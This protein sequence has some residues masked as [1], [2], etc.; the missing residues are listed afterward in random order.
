MS[1]RLWSPHIRELGDRIAALTVA[2]AAELSAY[3]EEIHG[4]G[5]PASAPL[6]DRDPEPV[7]E[8][9]EPAPTAF[10]VLL[11]GFEPLQRIAVIRRVRE[12]TGL[13]MKEAK[14]LVE[15][16]PCVL[17]EALPPAEAES[18]QAQLAAAGAKVSLRPCPA[19]A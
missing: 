2:G 1:N 14:D 10:D 11:N 19:A 5:L 16:G 12:L 3:L 9:E 18:L 17:R 7:P 13:G 6:L 8:E 4:L 15:A